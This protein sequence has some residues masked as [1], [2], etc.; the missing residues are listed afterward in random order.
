MATERAAL[1]R[2]RR[3]VQE[4]GGE[5]TRQGSRHGLE[6]VVVSVESR[7]AIHNGYTM[8]YTM[9]CCTMIYYSVVLYGIC[10]RVVQPSNVTMCQ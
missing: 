8:H 9:L 7:Y 6:T 3:L 4:S 2:T 5:E 1:R 10:H